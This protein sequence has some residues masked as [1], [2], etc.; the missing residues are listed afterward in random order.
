MLRMKFFFF[1]LFLSVLTNAKHYKCNK[2]LSC[3]CGYTNVEINARIINGEEAVPYSWSM[4]VSLRYDFFHDGNFFRHACAGT[5]LTDS[6][7]LTAAS[8]LEVIKDDIQFANATIAAGIHRRS[9]TTEIIRTI[10]DILIHP[11]W[12]GSWNNDYDIALLHLSEPLDFQMNSFITRTCLSSQLNNPEELIQYPP[13][14]TTL[15]VVGWGR[16]VSYGDDSNIL[17]Q[18]IVSS[19][20]HNNS[21][22][23][24]QVID[25]I[26]QFCAGSHD[27]SSGQIIISFF[28][29]YIL[30][31]LIYL[32][33]CYGRSIGMLSFFLY[34]S[35]FR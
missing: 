19:I 20:D 4:I 17:R 25:P 1:F 24:D 7:I 6:Y 32:G 33:P 34:K 13:V 5:I 29:Y 9:Q 14:N 31:L 21:K 22:C 2:N 26:R 15:A 23:T 3:G 8:C 27:A 28:L 18:T 10:D 11:N 12:K 30:I 16:T 35:F